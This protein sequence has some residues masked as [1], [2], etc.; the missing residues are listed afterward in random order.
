MEDLSSR[1]FNFI[2][3]AQSAN[4]N[5]QFNFSID[6]NLKNKKFSSV[7]GVNL[8]RTIQ[9]SVNNAMKYANAHH[10]VINAEK[11]QEVMQDCHANAFTI[12]EK[13]GIGGHRIEISTPVSLSRRALMHLIAV[14]D[15]QRLSCFLDARDQYLVFVAFKP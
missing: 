14:C 8:Y 5:I 1:I 15:N 10:I 7:V 6:E 3:H 12:E 4:H 9:E 11:F 2:E 13:N